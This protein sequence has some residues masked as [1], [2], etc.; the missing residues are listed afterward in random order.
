MSSVTK[1][2]LPRSP[3]GN[4][5]ECDEF[6]RA[7]PLSRLS[8]SIFFFLGVALHVGIHL[9]FLFETELAEPDAGRLVLDAWMLATEGPGVLTG[10]RVRSSPAYLVAIAFLRKHENPNVGLFSAPV[11]SNS[12]ILRVNSSEGVIGS[13]L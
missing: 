3:S 2:S 7:P 13:F 12:V 4:Q 8:L 1:S 11:V 5:R 10:Y 6:R 9:P